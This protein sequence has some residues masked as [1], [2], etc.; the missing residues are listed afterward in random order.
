MCDPV[1]AS[2]AIGGLTG[3][4]LYQGQEARKMQSQAS[5]AATAAA[6][7]AADQAD[8]ANNRLNGKQP[9]IMGMLSANQQAA[10]GGVGGTMLT[11]PQGVDP[12]SLLLGKTTLLGGGG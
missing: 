4:Q 5:D 6:T 10:K 9:D 11:G 1:T 3:L 7:K 12:N 2:I 8:Q